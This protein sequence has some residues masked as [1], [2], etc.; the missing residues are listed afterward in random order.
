[1]NMAGFILL[2]ASYNIGEIFFRAAQ[3]LI[4][5]M[6]TK[7]L[8][9]IPLMLFLHV[10][11]SLAKMYFG[12]MR[13]DPSAIIK[14]IAIWICLA[15]Y[16]P[17]VYA[18]YDATLWFTSLTG[19]DSSTDILKSLNTLSETGYLKKHT[20]EFSFP[21]VKVPFDD[22]TSFFTWLILA[23]ENGLAMIVRLFVER[24]KSMLLAFTLACGP[25]AFTIATIPGFG[26]PLATGY[27]SLSL[28]HSGVLRYPYW[29][30]LWPLLFTISIFHREQRCPKHQ[31][32]WMY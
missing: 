20:S 1:M 8:T 7:C 23:V 31:P 16:S 3:K 9:F 30:Q 13:F 15:A 10:V 2:Q 29:M 19:I 25:V 24:I 14:V 28:R 21:N 22:A 4:D 17:L 32:S 27:A 18:I 5:G 26:E 12:D 6:A 11:I